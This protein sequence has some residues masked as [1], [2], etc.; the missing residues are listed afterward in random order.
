M[1]GFI[2]AMTL[3]TLSCKSEPNDLK[4]ENQKLQKEID[5][6]KNELYKCNL[7]IESYEALPLNI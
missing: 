6:L 7:L 1:Y 3:L 4:T 2:I 5:S